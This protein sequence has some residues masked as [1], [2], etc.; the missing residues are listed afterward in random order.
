MSQRVLRGT[1]NRLSKI[2][3]KNDVSTQ[4]FVYMV[5]SENSDTQLHTILDSTLS[6]PTA[7]L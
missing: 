7:A 5:I 4:V 2:V 3:E 1:V 6:I